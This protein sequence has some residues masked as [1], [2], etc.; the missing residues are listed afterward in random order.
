M[1][2]DLRPDHLATVREILRRHVPDRGVWAFGSR[3]RGTAHIASD[4]DLCIRGDEPLGFERLGR[5]R[6]A[7]SASTLPFRVDVVEWASTAASFKK[8]IEKG[9]VVVQQVGWEEIT[10]G[11][12]DDLKTLKAKTHRDGSVAFAKIGVALTYNR[13]R[14][15][16]VDTSIDNNMLSARSINKSINPFHL[17]LIFSQVD[18]NLYAKGTAL[19]YLN[20]SDLQRIT[21]LAPTDQLWARFGALIQPL[22]DR[23]RKNVDESQALAQLRNLLLPKLMTG[24]IRVR[25]A[26]KAVEAVL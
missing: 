1:P 17:F 6:D 15:L 10:L 26:E 12:Q 4:L 24:A 21:L 13:M 11:E 5:L 14:L 25:D 2:V 19:P 22:F 23:I 20:I 7:F 3:I 18:F 16:T 9:R 8:V